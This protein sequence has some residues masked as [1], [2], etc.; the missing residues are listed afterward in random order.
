[1]I[2]A[3]HLKKKQHKLTPINST[4][5]L[6]VTASI[7][8]MHISFSISIGRPVLDLTVSISLS[9]SRRGKRTAA[10]LMELADPKQASLDGWMDG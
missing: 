7:R 6:S 5:L 1:L 3:F 4:R 2:A 8:S 9:L 10:Q